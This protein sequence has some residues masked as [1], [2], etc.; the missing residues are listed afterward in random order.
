MQTLIGGYRG[1]S[2]MFDVN[3]DR[4]L[5]LGV[6]VASLFLASYITSV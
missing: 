4:M 6:I 3:R 1:L 2:V 5:S